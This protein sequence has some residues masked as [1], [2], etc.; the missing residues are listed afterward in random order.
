MEKTKNI[1]KELKVEDD[2]LRK[3]LDLDQMNHLK[4]LKDTIAKKGDR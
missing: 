3:R 4:E 1:E 2:E